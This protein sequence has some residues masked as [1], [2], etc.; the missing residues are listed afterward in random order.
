[1]AGFMVGNDALFF[2]IENEGFL[3]ETANDALDSLL[4]V[5]DRDCLGR[6]TGSLKLLASIWEYQVT[7]T[8]R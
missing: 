1:M 8:Y 6:S 4:K 5:L 7:V 3:F 2:G